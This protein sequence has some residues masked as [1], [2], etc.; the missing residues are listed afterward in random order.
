LRYSPTY[1]D[2]PILAARLDSVK[3]GTGAPYRREAG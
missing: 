3:A 1:D 2:N